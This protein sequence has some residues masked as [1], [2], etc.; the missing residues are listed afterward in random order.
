MQSIFEKMNRVGRFT[1]PDFVLIS[2]YA[3]Q[4]NVMLA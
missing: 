1:L 2:G 3:N 4:Y